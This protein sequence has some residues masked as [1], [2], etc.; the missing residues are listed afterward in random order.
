M[1][2]SAT[3]LDYTNNENGSC[4]VTGTVAPTQ[5]G[6]ADICGG[7]ISYTWTFT[8]ICN[9][10]I[11]HV[12]NYTVDPAPPATFVEN[13]PPDITVNCDYVDHSNYDVYTGFVQFENVRIINTIEQ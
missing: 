7:T 4:L 12:Q 5:S 10:T 9:N 6:N 13:L 11:T 3:D 2:A 1:P 8:D